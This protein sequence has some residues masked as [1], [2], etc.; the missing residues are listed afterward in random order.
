MGRVRMLF[1]NEGTVSLKTSTC[2]MLTL[3]RI[4]KTLSSEVRHGIATVLAK[5]R[6]N[7]RGRHAFH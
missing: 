6:H 5:N 3:A 7:L 2:A 1:G 4:R